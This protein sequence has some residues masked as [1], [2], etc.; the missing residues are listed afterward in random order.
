VV[1]LLSNLFRLLW[2]VLWFV[3]KWS[4]LGLYYAIVGVYNVI[5]RLTL[6]SSGIV[7]WVGDGDTVRLDTGHYIRYIGLDAPE[8]HQPFYKESRDFNASLIL[9]KKVDLV[10]SGKLKDRHGRALAFVYR[11]SDGLF[12]NKEM[13]RAGW[14]YHYYKETNPK[15]AKDFIA[16]QQA[17][18]RAGCGY[19]G[20]GVLF[21]KNRVVATK[22]LI[23]HLPG[24][25]HVKKIKNAQYFNSFSDAF[26][27]GYAPC[28]ECIGE[29]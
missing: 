10:Y 20:T 3:F 4:I 28:R 29:N 11:K 13:V 17:A 27:N 24:C 12:V 25:R 23:F 9:N 16:I 18:I 2:S 14:A 8:K 19:W 15:F 5:T 1:Y 22:S 26:Y 6:P 7:T 21:K